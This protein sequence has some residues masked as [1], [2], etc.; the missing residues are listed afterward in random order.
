VRVCLLTRGD[1]FPAQHGAAVKIVQTAQGLSRRSGEPCFVVTEDRDRYHLV[2]GDR[3]T[4]LAYSPRVRAA[5]EWP[6][7]R[8]GGALSR[9]AMR[10]AGYPP[11]ELFLYEPALD[12]AWALRAIDVGRR[13]GVD[14]FQAE[15]PGYG[16]PAAAA[17]RALSGVRRARGAAGLPHGPLRVRSAVVQHNV[18]WDRLEEFGV[19]VRW[20][21]EVELGALRAVDE[22]IAVSA[23]D[24]R[25][26]AA[27][28]V[29]PEKMTVI[30][31]GVDVAG[32]GAGLAGGVR[33][34]YGIPPGVPLCFFHGTLHYWPNTEAVRLLAERILPRLRARRPDLH[35]LV[36][37]LSPPRYYESPGLVFAGPVDD[38]A[39]CIAAADVCVCPVEAGGGTRMKLLEYMAAG[40][41][42][43]STTKGA[44]GI[45]CT[46]GVELLL[47]DGADPFADAVDAL[48]GDPGRRARLG[49]AA[50]R[51]A[52]RYGWDAIAD[53]YLAL[54]RGE[55]RGTDWNPRLPAAPAPAVRVTAPLPADEPQIAAH[56][57]PRTL[58]KPRTLLLL[59]NRGCNLRC[60]F[61]D[62]WDAPEQMPVGP[63]LIPLLDEAVAIDV[64][65]LVITG[66]EPFLHPD[67]FVA[68]RAARDRGLAVNVTTNGTL[69][70]RRW[71]ELWEGGLSSIS[72][73]IDGLEATHDR[74]R[75]QKGAWGRTL[76]GLERVLARGGLPAS[77]YFTVTAENVHELLPVWERARALGAGFDFW[78]V[79]DAPDL[80]LRRPEH[81]AAFLD[82]V[83]TIGAVD[84]SVRAR[85]EYYR[86]GLSYHEGEAG[87]VRCLG[88]I[89]QLGVKYTGE[90]IP[91]CVWGGEGLVMGNVFE[92]PL[93][94]LW[95]SPEVQGFREQMFSRGCTAGC[96]NHSLY[97]FTQSTGL[98]ARRGT[99]P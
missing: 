81:Q 57:P 21:R 28:G 46:D 62:L 90:L 75:G 44:E 45:A 56:L 95:R 89:D 76:R 74:L 87:P 49:A 60:A 3:W 53:A 33:G 94:E 68:T 1:L 93:R 12:P 63:R 65:V 96:F 7:V 30:P 22:V 67:L 85:A 50:A 4:T 13:H 37:G 72:F 88:F 31:H 97:E 84:P 11:E 58:S 40:R 59:I 26:M 99:T 80:A 29:P 86:S 79:N 10:A 71:A 42:I 78:P 15:F 43:V 61:C 9:R 38:L 77:V 98:P 70:D 34:K 19:D 23:D 91:C 32:L 41:P 66:G 55:G 18:E 39:D 24:R 6:P 36:A 25:R 83:A 92:R 69:I 82:A 14:V 48:L 5:E 17:A 35:L 51:F 27:A 64:K 20:I 54:Y 16:P 47:A 73:S 8:G 52:S 2:E